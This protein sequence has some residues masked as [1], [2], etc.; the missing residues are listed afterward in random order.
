MLDLILP[1]A[2]GFLGGNFLFKD[3]CASLRSEIDDLTAQ[4]SAIRNQYLIDR[5]TNPNSA[6]S[7]E[8]N[9][10]AGK[11]INKSRELLIC[12]GEGEQVLRELNGVNTGKI[13]D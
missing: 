11:R 10:L 13:I 12:T 9:K 7:A 8:Y 5:R 4:M 6:I 2:G 3:K 1:F